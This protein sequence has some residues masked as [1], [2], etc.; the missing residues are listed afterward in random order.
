MLSSLTEVSAYIS[1]IEEYVLQLVGY[2]P[3]TPNNVTP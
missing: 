1:E 3:V 2:V